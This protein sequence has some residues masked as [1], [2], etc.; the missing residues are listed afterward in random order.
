MYKSLSL[1]VL[2]ALAGCASVG[3]NEYKPYKSR[4]K[5]AYARADRSVTFQHVTTNFNACIEA[6]VA[7]A[8]IIDDIQF[9]ETERTIQV[10]FDIDHREFDWMDHGG[11]R[12]YK[13]GAENKGRIKVGWTVDKPARISNLKTRAKPGYMI[14]VYGK[15]WRRE[16]HEIQLAATAVR[17]IKESDFEI[18]PRSGTSDEGAEEAKD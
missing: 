10:A 6:E 2:L 1:L 12:P 15:P 17:P 13:L 16:G 9:K 14:M 3:S 4:E 11:G 5:Q 8:G 7:W 18:L